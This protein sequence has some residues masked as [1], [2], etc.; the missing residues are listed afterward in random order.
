MTCEVR[1]PATSCRLFLNGFALSASAFL[2]TT[3]LL[4]T[5]V[6]TAVKSVP[7][8]RRHGFG[9]VLFFFLTYIQLSTIISEEICVNQPPRLLPLAGW[10]SRSADLIKT[11]ET[12]SSDF[13]FSKPPVAPSEDLSPSLD[14]FEWKEQGQGRSFAP[15]CQ[16]PK[17]SKMIFFFFLFDLL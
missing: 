13:H 15:L 17:R 6:P 8:A 7:F 3:L 9:R 4:A 11:E 14:I 2:S 16:H 12:I 5:V 1:W 10:L